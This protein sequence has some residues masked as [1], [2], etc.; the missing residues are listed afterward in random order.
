MKIENNETSVIV[1]EQKVAKEVESDNIGI[2]PQGSATPDSNVS[3][4]DITAV[5][6]GNLLR[7]SVS[8][9]EMEQSDLEMDKEESVQLTG[10]ATFNK[11]KAEVELPNADKEVEQK[12][13]MMKNDFEQNVNVEKESTSAPTEPLINGG[14]M[15]DG[16]SQ[17]ETLEV[18]GLVEEKGNGVKKTKGKE[19]N[20]LTSGQIV[21]LSVLMG[22]GYSFGKLKI[23]RALNRNALKKKIKS[24]KLYGIVS[25]CLVTTAQVCLDAGLEIVSFDGIPITKDT[26]N[27]DKILIIIDGAHRHVATME[28]NSML[29]KGEEM[30]ENYYYLPLTTKYKVMELLREAN[31]VTKPWAGSDFLT[32][33]IMSREEAAENKMLIWVQAKLEKSGDTAIWEWATLNKSVPSKSKLIKAAGTDEKADA[34]FRNISDSSKFE[35]GKSIYDAFAKIFA[36]S[37]LGCKFFPEWVIDKLFK[38]DYMSGPK[39]AE[40]LIDFASKLNRQDAE[41]IESIKG[42]DKAQNVKNELDS[43]YNE[44]MK[45]PESPVM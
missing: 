13:E 35:R 19:K 31:V 10:T 3:A 36:E 39:A 14:S 34:I 2:K 22:W 5:E 24:I 20:R 18:N 6:G 38:L 8:A 37:I 9:S 12:Y 15:D 16:I 11:E 29:R 30:K 44:R 25:P 7:V 32:S 1:T 4:K 26:P 45:E 23:N 21:A 27:L 33:L 42:A 41:R 28:I 43:L 17:A 40:H